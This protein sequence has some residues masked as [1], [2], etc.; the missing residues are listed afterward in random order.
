MKIYLAY[1]N[2]KLVGVFDKLSDVP[3]N[4]LTVHVTKNKIWY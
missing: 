3:T 1:R 4:C 2:S